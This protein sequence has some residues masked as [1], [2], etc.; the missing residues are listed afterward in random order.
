MKEIIKKILFITV[1]VLVFA[2]LFCVIHLLIVNPESIQ[3]AFNYFF[4]IGNDNRNKHYIL[5]GCFTLIIIAIFE[6]ICGIKKHIKR[7]KYEKHNS[8]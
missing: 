7:K 8:R 5:F 4:G 3:Q 6:T 2:M 1:L